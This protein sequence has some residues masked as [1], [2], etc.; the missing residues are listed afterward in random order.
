M[1]ILRLGAGAA[2]YKKPFVFFVL[3][4]NLRRLVEC[5]KATVQGDKK[6][7]TLRGFWNRFVEN[8]SNLLRFYG[9]LK[10]QVSSERLSDKYRPI[11]GEFSKIVINNMATKL[12]LRKKI[13]WCR[14]PCRATGR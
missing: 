8:L 1:C 6:I 10:L 2:I 3:T 13:K 14:E 12:N 7:W 9:K 4:L 11:S 5:H